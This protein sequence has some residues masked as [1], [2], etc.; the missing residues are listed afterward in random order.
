MGLKKALKQRFPYLFE[1]YCFLIMRLQIIR[2]KR[3][4][5]RSPQM[6]AEQ[7]Y[8]NAFGK[9]ADLQ[10]P[11]TFNEKLNWL[12]INWFDERGFL[13]ANKYEVRKFVEEKGLGFLLNELYGYWED[14]RAIDFSALPE[15]YV[16]KSTHDSGHLMPVTD[17]SKLNERIARFRMKWWTSNDY[18]FIAG[19][20][21][22]FTKKPGI[23]CERF[24]ED[25]THGELYDYKF[26]CFNG[27]PQYVFFCSDRKNKV[28][29]DF[30]DMQWQKMPFR[31][32]Y[33]NSDK[34]VEK[35]ACFEEMK[36]YARTLSE[37]F[38]FVRV[39]FYE[40]DGKVYFGELTFFHGGGTGEFHPDE[41][42]RLFGDKICLPQK[43]DPWKIVFERMEDKK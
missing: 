41:I 24:I 16:L 30:Y 43:N 12:K 10:E 15:R 9:K 37:D 3:M 34:T 4:L 26:F 1:I 39:D 40:V 5:R 38:P 14:V 18:C 11:K 19:E 27:E 20:W 28:K 17:P 2:G 25:R 36:Q 31:W 6:F 29:A 42:D 32:H 7:L 33:E 21:P 8:E 22:Y 23:V 13:C 35:P